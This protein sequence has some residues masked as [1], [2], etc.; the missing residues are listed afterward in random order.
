[1]MRVVLDAN[2]LVSALIS[3]RGSPAAILACWEQGAFELVVSP[4]ILDEL[5]RVLRYPRI[6]ARYDLPEALVGRFLELLQRVATLVEPQGEIAAIPADASDNRYLEA[7][8]AGGA[9]YI[10][11]GDAHLLALS[12]HQGTRILA[13]AAF[14]ALLKL[15]GQG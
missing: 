15:E 10:V 8:L 2:V 7:A 5:G 1:M 13:P 9:V 11:S 14:L 3:S 6:Q 4:A 12:A